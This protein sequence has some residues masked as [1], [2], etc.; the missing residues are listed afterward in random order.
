[1]LCVKLVY[2]VEI[3]P[4]DDADALEA[5]DRFYLKGEGSATDVVADAIEDTYK[6]LLQP[7]M[8]YEFRKKLKEIADTSAIEVFA[9]NAKK[10]F[11]APPVGQK[12]IIGIDPGFRTGC[13]VVVLDEQGALLENTTIYPHPPQNQSYEATETIK[14]LVY[15]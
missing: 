13:K 15:K 7:S 10:L 9:D 5:I 8:E 6:R 1:M 3:A 14:A 11:L 4:L 2:W 12:K